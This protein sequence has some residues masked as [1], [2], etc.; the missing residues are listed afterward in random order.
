MKQMFSPLTHGRS[1]ST[2]K[3]LTFSMNFVNCTQ[4]ANV[5]DRPWEQRFLL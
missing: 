5:R 1:E 2:S 3:P 4:R